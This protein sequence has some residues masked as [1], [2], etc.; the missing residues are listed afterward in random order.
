MCKPRGRFY[1]VVHLHDEQH[2]WPLWGIITN[3]Q[4]L[5]TS[6]LCKGLVGPSKRITPFFLFFLFIHKLLLILLHSINWNLLDVSQRFSLCILTDINSSQQIWTQSQLQASAATWSIPPNVAPTYYTEV[7]VNWGRDRRRRQ[8][9]TGRQV[10]RC[11]LQSSVSTLQHHNPW[12][13]SKRGSGIKVKTSNEVDGC[14]CKIEERE[15][16]QDHISA[17]NCKAP[18]TKA[19]HATAHKS[20]RLSKLVVNV[21]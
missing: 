13:E 11:Y 5:F 17:L 4:I 16:W 3:C 21:Y 7:S 12:A 15:T 20:P 14:L 19:A 1:C 9:E 8:R 2:S 18:M 10:K 6:V